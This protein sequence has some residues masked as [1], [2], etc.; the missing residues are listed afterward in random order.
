M[1]MLLRRLR[2]PR[3]VQEPGRIVENGRFQPQK[4]LRAIANVLW[5]ATSYAVDFKG[6][7]SF[8]E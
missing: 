5:M 1:E 3:Q 6:G 2:L 8:G 4:E 7:R